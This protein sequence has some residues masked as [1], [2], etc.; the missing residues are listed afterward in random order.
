MT[1]FQREHLA[2]TVY[3]LGRRIDHLQERI[4]KC[5]QD[6]DLKAVTHLELKIEK[7]SSE[8]KGI[9][10]T[11]FVLGYEVCW[12]HTEDGERDIPNIV[13]IKTESTVIA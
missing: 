13:K 11:L 7:A 10:D 2:D 8:M 6:G 9:I 12:N 3:F 5:K 4:N 1:K